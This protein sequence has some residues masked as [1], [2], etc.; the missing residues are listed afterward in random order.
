MP[1]VDKVSFQSTNEKVFFGGDAA[2]GPENII[3]AVAHGHQA[4]ISIDLFLNGSSV[5]EERPAPGTNLVSTKMGIHQWAYDSAVID[6]DRQASAHLPV[7]QALSS[8]SI[9]SEIGF[10]LDVAYTEAERC[11]NCD[12][13]TVFVESKCIEC[14]GCTDICPT[15]CI[16]FINNDEE[17]SL[18]NKLNAPSLNKDT[19]LYVSTDLPTGRVMVKDEDVCLHCGL[20]A[21]RCPT[22]AWDMQKFLYTVTKAGNEPAPLLVEQAGKSKKQEQAA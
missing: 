5:T 19:D 4:A 3:T 20:C 22:S 13:Q 8:I 21:E 6:D 12:V 7:E 11:L 14:D 1:I 17:D 10:N 15:D 2:F 16:T 18:R 9:E